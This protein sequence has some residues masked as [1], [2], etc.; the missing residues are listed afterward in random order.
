M[1]NFFH[2]TAVLLS[3]VL[4]VSCFSSCGKTSYLQSSSADATFSTRTDEE[5]GD[6]EAAASIDD[7][8]KQSDGEASS[9]PESASAGAPENSVPAMIFVEAAGAVAAPGVYRVPAGS[10]VFEVIALAGGLL[11]EADTAEINQAAEV[12]DGTK[13]YIRRQGEEISPT[14]SAGAAAGSGATTDTAGSSASGG[15][16]NINTAD[17]AT[18]MTLPGIGQSKADAIISYRQEKG[19][20]KK[21]SD[22]KKIPGIKDGLFSKIS[23]KITV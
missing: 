14:A 21:T 5:S 9:D 2:G 8:E 7:A 12:A 17:A 15:L 10:R 13:I 22:I 4:C 20:F 1:K 16:V 18:L 11:P 3:A 23:D 6:E 19:P